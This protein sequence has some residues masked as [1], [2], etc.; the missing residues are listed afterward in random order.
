MRPHQRPRTPRLIPSMNRK[1]LKGQKQ[2]TASAWI[3]TNKTPRK[4][5]LL[6]HKKMNKWMQPGGHIE[7][8]ENPIETVVREVFEET[9]I[10]I[11]FLH[12]KIIVV[13]DEG[14]FLPIPKFIMEQTI[15]PHKEDP[16]HF[17]IDLQYVIKVPEQVLTFSQKE[18]HTIGWFTK[19]EALKLSIHEDTKVVLNSIL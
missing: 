7:S 19:K 13:D 12:K 14:S 1:T 18:S 6:H 5:L 2:F 11:S 9:G 8:N 16:E 15:A 3:I 4:I 17:H 10:E